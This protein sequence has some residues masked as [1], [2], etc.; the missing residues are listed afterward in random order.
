MKKQPLDNDSFVNRNLEMLVKK[1]PRQKIVIS[2]GEIFTG[3][4]AV[5]KARKRYPK[6]IPLFMPVPGPEE[7]THIL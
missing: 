2:H 1:F 6:A 7:F 4:D 5:K 3:E